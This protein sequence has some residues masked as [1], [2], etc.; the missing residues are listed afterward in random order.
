MP[1]LFSFF[2]RKPKIVSSDNNEDETIYNL[3]SRIDLLENKID[4]NSDG[5]INYE[6]MKNYFVSVLP[7]IKFGDTD[8]IVTKSELINYIEEKIRPLSDPH[9]DIISLNEKLRDELKISQ[10][11]SSKWKEAYETLHETFKILEKDSLDLHSKTLSHVSE[12][13]IKDY[14]DKNIIQNPDMNFKWIPDGPESKIWTIM[15]Y[16]SMKS[17]DVCLSQAGIDLPGHRLTL[18]IRPDIYTD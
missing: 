1:R 3:K 14:V 12:E 13:S 2:N 11:E 4:S 17:I 9:R 10:A 5:K 7:N 15:L 18:A 16:R 6:E 8:S